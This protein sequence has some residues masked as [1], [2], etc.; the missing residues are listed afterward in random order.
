MRAAQITGYGGTD[1]LAF[2][3]I[4]EQP[5]PNSKQVLVEVY[6]AGVNPFDWKVR[7]GLMRSMAEPALP[8]TLG[9]DCAG[10][11]TAVGDEVT[12]FEIGQAVYGQAGALSGKGSYAE[13]TCV[14]ASALAL[15]PESVDFVTAAALPL[16][17]VSAYQALVDHMQLQAGQRILIHGGA[18]GIG[19]LA[20]QL[21]KQ[22][23][24]YVITT[25]TAADRD[26]VIGLGADEVIDY[27]TQN[28]VDVLSDL[29]AVYDTIGGETN[30]K[31]YGLLK[32]GGVLVSMVEPADEAIASEHQ[33]TYTFQ[34]TSVTTERLNEIAALV[35]A[36]KLKTNVDKVFPLQAAAEA[37]EYLKT[38]H[39]RGKVVI[40]V[41]S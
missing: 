21:A 30:K 34:F 11:V 28:F 40:T 20:I 9:G 26:F 37:L 12:D 7:E 8:A 1:V 2:T 23:G 18:G 41:K 29:D 33:I 38:A 35:D 25:A 3:D 36:G 4:A 24:A 39:P 17:S 32:P 15:K 27:Q 31:S 16:A 10:V 13:Y 5:T 22:R 14:K 19:T 6:A